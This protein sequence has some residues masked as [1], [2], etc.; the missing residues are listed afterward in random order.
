MRPLLG[1]VALSVLLGAPA[2]RAEE[3]NVTIKEYAY[4]PAQ[5]TVAA[6]TK[7]TWTN[8][9]Q[10]PH[11]VVEEGKKFRSAALDTNDS[12]SFVLTQ[13]GTYRYF[14]SLHPQMV[15]TITVVKEK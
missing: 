11:T 12:Y 7:V 4:G 8:H 10:V 3:A 6:G 15:G 14:C 2:A 13:P 1:V 9:D 5:L